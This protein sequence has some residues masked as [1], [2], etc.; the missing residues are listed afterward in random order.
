MAK[1]AVQEQLLPGDN[2]AE[3]VDHAAQLGFSGIEFA[4][5]RLDE[6]LPDIAEALESAGVVASGLNM[7]RSDGCLSADVAIRQRAADALREAL[8]CAQDLE[9]EYVAFVPQCSASDLPDLTPVASVFDLQ[10]ELLIWLLHGFSDLA[11]I[12]DCQLALQPVNHYETNFITRLE[13]AAWFR[14]QVNDHPKITIAANLFHLALEE[15]DLLESLRDHGDDISV[16]YLSEVN[17]RLPGCGLLPFAAI[18]DA[19]QDMRYDGWLVLEADTSGRDPDA[20][21]ETASELRDC[22]Q[23]LRDSGLA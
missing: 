6:R 9:A 18:G 1:L 23:F 5:E 2:T 21:R 8:A 19:L 14:R 11:E 17:Q 3:R 10:K 15:R 12:M 22:V 4:A 7:G 20:N 16:V 13:Q